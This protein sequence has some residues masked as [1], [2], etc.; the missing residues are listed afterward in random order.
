MS[1]G[2]SA[3]HSST[4]G[5]PASAPTSS[6]TTLEPDLNGREKDVLFDLSDPNDLEVKLDQLSE[7]EME[8][9]LKQAYKVN[10]ELKNTL[11]RQDQ[12][13][14]SQVDQTKSKTSAA[15]RSKGSTSRESTTLP[16]LRTTSGSRQFTSL[17]H[18]SSSQHRGLSPVKPG[19]LKAK[20]AV[21]APTRHRPEWDDRFNF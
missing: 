14:K 4:T 2:E 13:G 18:R 16:P 10:Q 5:S 3:R 7:M 1:D 6:K 21:Q 15:S 9:L 19:R 8:E 11:H 12:S 17:D 20:T